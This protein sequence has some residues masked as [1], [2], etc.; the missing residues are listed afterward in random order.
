[1]QI[2]DLPVVVTKTDSVVV[3]FR[4]EY[5]PMASSTVRFV[6]EQEALVGLAQKLSAL[7]PD[8]EYGEIGTHV[9]RVGD[10]KGYIIYSQV[11]TMTNF[12]MAFDAVYN[13]IVAVEWLKRQT[14]KPFEL[15]P[16]L[17]NM[18][19]PSSVSTNARFIRSLV[20][21]LTHDVVLSPH[22]ISLPVS[23]LPFELCPSGL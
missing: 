22:R 9:V 16:P 7:M 8:A 19:Q 6:L 13:V 5:T 21:L 1:L 23:R 3:P 2:A 10:S 14:W 18:G 20:C 12:W 17:N 4:E 15:A 11:A